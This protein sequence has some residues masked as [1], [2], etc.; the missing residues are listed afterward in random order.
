LSLYS[1]CFGISALS[2]READETGGT[3]KTICSQRS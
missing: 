2:L 1:A 3:V